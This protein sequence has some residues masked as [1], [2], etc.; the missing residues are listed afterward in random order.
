MIFGSVSISGIATA[1]PAP[2]VQ[3][4]ITSTIPVACIVQLVVPDNTIP[5]QVQQ[6]TQPKG[7]EINERGSVYITKMHKDFLENSYRQAVLAS[8][9]YAPFMQ[10]RQGMQL[11]DDEK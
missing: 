10:A 3:I 5:V 11:Q 2:A 9:N 7:L 6:A 1:H 8:K 4:Q